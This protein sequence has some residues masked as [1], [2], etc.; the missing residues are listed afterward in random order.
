[1]PERASEAGR[2][3]RAGKLCIS[4]V[5]VVR[6]K[7]STGGGGRSLKDNWHWQHGGNSGG[8]EDMSVIFCHL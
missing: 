2:A 5:Y 6:R 4:M 7:Y 3:R 8:R 1:M